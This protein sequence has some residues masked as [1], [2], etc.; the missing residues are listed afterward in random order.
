MPEMDGL[1]LTD[2]LTTLEQGFPVII[3]TLDPE[4]AVKPHALNLGKGLPV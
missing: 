1:E 2:Q 4:R 3:H